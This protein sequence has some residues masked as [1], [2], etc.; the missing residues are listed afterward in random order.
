[1]SPSIV[2]NKTKI[3]LQPP[4]TSHIASN[5][6]EFSKIHHNEVN[7]SIWE[8]NLSNALQNAAAEILNNNPDFKLTIVP[9]AD[10]IRDILVDELGSGKNSLTLINDISKLATM[11]CDL[12]KIDRAWIRLDSIDTPMCPRFHADKVKCRLVTTYVGPA[13]EWLPHHQV[14]RSKLGHGNNGLPDHESGL[15]SDI[16]SIEQLKT[17]HVALLKGEGWNGN[18]GAGLVHLSLIHID[19][20]DE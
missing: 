15:F 19:A 17:G 4:V 6:E 12:F 18:Q 13:T 20:A 16:N 1:M 5:H 3:G 2:T 14:D 10:E 8:R 7:I 11:F 9:K